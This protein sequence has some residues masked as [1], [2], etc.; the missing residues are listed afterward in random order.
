MAFEVVKIGA[1]LRNGVWVGSYPTAA[2]AS[3]ACCG[4]FVNVAGDKS[5]AFRAEWY[6]T[7]AGTEI[8]MFSRGDRLLGFA[9]YRR[10]VRA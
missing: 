8:G 1:A 3:Q 5:Q 2:R 6:S 7:P 10:A 4:L 9:G